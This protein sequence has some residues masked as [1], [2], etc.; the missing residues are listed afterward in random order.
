MHVS[1][2]RFFFTE[3]V[4]WNSW[5][6]PSSVW[7][8]SCSQKNGTWSSLSF[9]SASYSAIHICK[10]SVFKI[11]F[12]FMFFFTPHSQYC[13]TVLPSCPLYPSVCGAKFFVCL[14]SGFFCTELRHFASFTFF[15]VWFPMYILIAVFRPCIVKECAAVQPQW[16]GGNCSWVLDTVHVL[17]NLCISHSDLTPIA[18]L[19]LLL[20]FIFS[21]LTVMNNEVQSR[22]S[23]LCLP[24]MS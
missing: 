20:D 16:S 6:H 1:L 4:K 18:S 9:L 17:E 24:S 8:S 21:D 10:S 11:C 12:H 7:R 2:D 19:F 23:E 22:Q 14:I 5:Q 3:S 15:P 13:K